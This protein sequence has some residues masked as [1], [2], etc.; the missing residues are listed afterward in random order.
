MMS[1]QAWAR[2]LAEQLPGWAVWYTSGG[3]I[4]RGWYAV[5]APPGVGPLE[6]YELPNRIGPYVHPRQLRA[7]ARARYGWEDYCGSCGVPAR[8]CGH[9]QPERRARA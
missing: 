8:E 4:G 5:P 1:V 6:K 2:R 9:R 7:D 3:G